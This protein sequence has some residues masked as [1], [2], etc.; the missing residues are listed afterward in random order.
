[1]GGLYSLCIGKGLP[2]E[3]LKAH[4]NTVDVKSD[5]RIKFLRPE[6]EADKAAAEI[7]P[8]IAMSIILDPIAEIALRCIGHGLQIP[9]EVR[10]SL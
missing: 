8:H 1:M 9:A 10:L 5:E 7:V 6:D 4:P 3:L 2:H